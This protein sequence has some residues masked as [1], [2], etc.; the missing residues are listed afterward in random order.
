DVDT[1]TAGINRDYPHAGRE[2]RPRI[3]TELEY[4]VTIQTGNAITI[5]LL[6]GMALCVLLIACANVAG[7]LLSRSTARA[8]EIA[9]R[10]AIGARRA[11]LVRQLLLES[12]LISL[13]G[14]T[15]GLLIAYAGVQLFRSVP[16]PP[17]YPLAL[18]FDVDGNVLL[19]TAAV[20]FVSTILFGLIPALRAS[21]PSLVPALKQIDAVN[22]GRGRLWGRNTLVAGQVALSLVLLAVSGF[23]FEGFRTE[24]LGGP[25]FRVDKIATTTFDPGLIH[26]S[27]EQIQNFYARLLKTVRSS[28]NVDSAALSSLV[29]FEAPGSMLGVIPDGTQLRRDQEALTVFD[30]V[31]T[32]GF[33]ETFEIP[34]VKGRGF[35]ETDRA[36]SPRVA[37]VNQRFAEHY[38]PHQNAVGKTMRLW[39]SDGTVVQVVGVTR[40][41]K[42]SW[43]AE[44]P[45][46]FVFLPLSQNPNTAMAVVASTKHGGPATLLPVIR[47][48][49][50]SVDRNVP[51]FAPLTMPYIFENNAVRVPH[52]LIEMIGSLGGMALVLAVIGLYGLT[53]YSVSRR[54]REIGIR[55][56]IGA[57]RLKVARM[58][59]RQGLILASCG[60]AA[61]LILAF[62]AARA[63]AATLVFTFTRSGAAWPIAAVSLFL[64]LT[65]LAAAYVPARRAS[66]IDPMRALREE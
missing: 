57:D 49:A 64:L 9:V 8:R 36:D 15:A 45:T 61:G 47:H 52:I 6:A 34:V 22:P 50:E 25:G 55:M 39:H 46:D 38:W 65:T 58:V 14:G 13:A 62:L 27:P 18:H 41:F 26:Y 20:A 16:T 33:F 3:Q 11:T 23:M 5:K 60:I 63:I 35:A 53:A 17:D 43:M 19:F 37:I 30:G 40:N 59:L 66:L 56:A 28:P 24:I 32:D 1:L 42:Y 21:K 10:L 44:S 12:L 54:T 51:I 4:R 29:P 2:L 31:V 48:A 7:L